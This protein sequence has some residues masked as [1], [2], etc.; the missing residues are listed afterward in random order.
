MFCLQAI[1]KHLTVLYKLCSVLLMNISKRTISPCFCKALCKLNI[2]N[3]F[4]VV[5]CYKALRRMPRDLAGMFFYYHL[6]AY[7]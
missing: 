3:C 5:V 4:H 1:S 6:N 7:K 2:L